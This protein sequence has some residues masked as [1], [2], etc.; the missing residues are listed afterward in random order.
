M[1]RL[2]VDLAKKCWQSMIKD[3]D[4]PISAEAER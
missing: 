3:I 2:F 4:M 1:S